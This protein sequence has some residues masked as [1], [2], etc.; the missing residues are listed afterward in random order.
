M[1]FTPFFSPISWYPIVLVATT[2][3]LVARTGSGETKVESHASSD[4]QPALL[5]KTAQSNPEAS[6]TN[7]SEETPCTWQPWLACTA[8][9]PPQESLVRDETRISLPV[10]PSLTRTTLGQLCVAPRTSRSLPV[11]TAPGRKPRVSG[12]TA[13]AAVQYSALNHCAT[14]EASCVPLCCCLCHTALLYLGQ[15]AVVNENLFSTSRPG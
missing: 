9:G 5:L 2:L 6:R 15:V 3:S 4:T 7:V 10:K 8:P 13:G 1:D 11:T 14:R 12:G